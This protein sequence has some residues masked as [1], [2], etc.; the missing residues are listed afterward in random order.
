MFSQES[1]VCGNATTTS[2]MKR[3][4]SDTDFDSTSE[5]EQAE[6]EPYQGNDCMVCDAVLL[7]VAAAGAILTAGGA[8]ESIDASSARGDP[9]E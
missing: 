1:A 8:E 7:G 6:R 5:Q 3:L 4:S 2:G 9:N